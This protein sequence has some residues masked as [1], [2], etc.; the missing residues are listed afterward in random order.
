MEGMQSSVTSPDVTTSQQC[1]PPVTTQSG[2][3]DEKPHP[4]RLVEPDDN[5]D[6]REYFQAKRRKLR[7][8]FHD[9]GCAQSSIFEGV[10]IYVTGWT[11][12]NADE[13]KRM[14][15]AHGGSYE[16]NLYTN[17]KITH[18][19]ATNLPNAKVKTL[20]EAIVCTP[21]WI[22]ASITAGQQLPVDKYRL[23]APSR[24][25]KKLRFEKIWPKD[26]QY[27]LQPKKFVPHQQKAS[28]FGKMNLLVKRKAF[29]QQK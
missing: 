5:W 9:M 18:T 17:P 11:Q 20:G 25:Q 3:P 8:Q 16:Y 1:G 2:D 29:L 26:T 22:V 23:Y 10:T 28:L 6:I 12:P 7:D 24:G 4:P 19:I 27:P 21:E 13:L 15:H 14:I